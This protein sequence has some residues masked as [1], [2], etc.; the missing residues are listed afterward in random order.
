MY[1]KKNYNTY[2]FCATTVKKMRVI[3][4]L[5]LVT[6]LTNISAYNTQTYACS[7]G[8]NEIFSS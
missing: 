5:A 2:R 1:Q 7:Q 8:K 6:A 3:N 4:G